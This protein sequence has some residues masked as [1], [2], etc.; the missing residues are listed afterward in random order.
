MN[1][2]EWLECVVDTD[3]EINDQYPYPIRRKG[4]TKVISESVDNSCGYVQCHL[5]RKK[6]KKHRIIAEQYI[7]NP[8]NL[9]EVDHINHIRDDN[10][11]DNLR[12]VSKSTNDRNKTTYRGVE[13]EYVDNISEDFI[14]LTHYS[15]HRF[16][17]DDSF[18]TCSHYHNL[19]L[20]VVLY[21]HKK[22]LSA[23]VIHNDIEAT[24]GPNTI[25]YSTITE[26]IR[27]ESFPSNNEGIENEKKILN[28][29]QNQI[30]VER[31]YMKSKEK[32]G[33]YV[34]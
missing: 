10:R 11:I 9:P 31:D 28:D 3:Y 15:N 17:E 27:L 30:L 20:I 26:Y 18:Y 34:K 4:S 22:R 29:D 14:K 32:N 21:L 24:L 25:G 5:N 16:E 1:T 33:D 6:Y 2:G 7:D 8:D 12:W 19:N 23:R 13:Q